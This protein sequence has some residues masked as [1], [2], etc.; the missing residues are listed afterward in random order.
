MALDAATFLA[1]N[2]YFNGRDTARVTAAIAEAEKHF[3][4]SVC[5]DLYD[6]LVEAQTRVI[7]LGDPNGMPTSKTGASELR[8]DAG[9]RLQSLKRLV[10]IRGVG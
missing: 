7:L 4:A 6:A 9:E 1:A 5:G 8:K 3:D 10:P 2:T